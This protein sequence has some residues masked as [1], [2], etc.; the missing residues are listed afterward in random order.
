MFLRERRWPL[1]LKS[2]HGR[3]LGARRPFAARF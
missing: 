1:R 3:H 2:S